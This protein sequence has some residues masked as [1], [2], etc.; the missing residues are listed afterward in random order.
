MFDPVKSLNGS[1]EPVENGVPICTQPLQVKNVGPS[2]EK[3]PVTARMLAGLTKVTDVEVCVVL[4]PPTS[5]VPVIGVAY[6][7]PAKAAIPVVRIAAVNSFLV[8]M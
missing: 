4:S 6:A 3:S 1:E 7:E 8:S 5:T 2:S